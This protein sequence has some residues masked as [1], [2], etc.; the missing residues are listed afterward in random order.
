MLAAL[1]FARIGHGPGGGAI[2][3]VHVY[4][5]GFFILLAMIIVLAAFRATDLLNKSTTSRSTSKRPQTGR[6]QPQSFWLVEC[7]AVG[8]PIGL[9]VGGQGVE[10]CKGHDD[11]V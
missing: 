5:A 2:T 4:L 8:V 1:S 10:V 7:H 3:I 6:R 11:G 9:V